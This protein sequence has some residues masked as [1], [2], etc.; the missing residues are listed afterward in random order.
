MDQNLQEVLVQPSIVELL[1]LLFLS[2]RSVSSEREKIVSIKK[3]TQ[4]VMWTC[5]TTLTTTLS[6]TLNPAPGSSCFTCPGAGVVLNKH[7]ATE[8]L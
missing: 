7:L 4:S 5:S 2:L 1:L 6:T 8:R 3:T